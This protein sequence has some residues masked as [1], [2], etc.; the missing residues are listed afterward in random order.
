M[1]GMLWGG[2]LLVRNYPP[3]NKNTLIRALTEEWN[4]LPQQLLDNVVQNTGPTSHIF[5][6][7]SVTA[8]R[9]RDEILEPIVRLYA[10]GAG[11]TFVLMD[12]NARPHRA[13]IVDDYLEQCFST[14]GPRPTGW[15]AGVPQGAT[16]IELETVLQEEW[17]LLDRGGS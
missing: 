5:K 15:G 9:Y 10:A 1:W 16:L 17:R 7:G 4:K 3:T 6:R 11:P 8:V 13:D 14:R 2:K 12:D